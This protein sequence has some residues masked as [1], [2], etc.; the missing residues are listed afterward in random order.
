MCDALI[1]EADFVSIGTNDLVQYVLAADRSNPNLSD[2]YFS[3][4]PSILRLI[5]MVI[6]SANQFCKSVILCG[7][8][9]ADPLMIPLLLGLGI[10]EFS[11]AA[12]HIP[13]VKHTIRKWRIL[14]A[15]RLAESALEYT[16]THD[17]KKFLLDETAR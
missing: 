2:L 4:H 13:F 10:R 1:R 15:C 5:R 14:E 17:L 3:T 9:A 12:R 7:E 8:S 6:S 16:S 11:V